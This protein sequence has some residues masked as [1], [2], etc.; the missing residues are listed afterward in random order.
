M[1]ILAARLDDLNINIAVLA[2]TCVGRFAVVYDGFSSCKDI[3]DLFLIKVI[4]QLLGR[5][6]E[7]SKGVVGVLRDAADCVAA[8]VPCGDL[9]NDFMKAARHKNPDVRR[10]VVMWFMRAMIKQ[11]AKEGGVSG[12]GLRGFLKSDIRPTVDLLVSLLED[13][14]EGVRESCAEV[15]GAM[16]FV[17]G[18]NIV[19]AIEKSV[20]KAKFAKIREYSSIIAGKPSVVAACAPKI[21]APVKVKQVAAS[22]PS[23][24]SKP[25]SK[26]STP[27][28]SNDSIAS[29]VQSYSL[30]YE[31]SYDSSKEHVAEKLENSFADLANSNWKLRLECTANLFARIENGAPN[32]LKSEAVIH[33]L[34]STPGYGWKESNF[35]VVATQIQ[36]FSNLCKRSDFNRSCM[37]L[38]V[39]AL[40]GKV[41]DSKLRAHVIEFLGSC[42]TK[43]GPGGTIFETYDAINAIKSPKSI[44]D[45]LKWINDTIASFGVKSIDIKGLTAFV[46][47]YCGHVNGSVRAMAI[48]LIASLMSSSTLVTT[49]VKDLSPSVLTLVEAE[50]VLNPVNPLDDFEE[51][52]VK[53]IVDHGSDVQAVDLNLKISSALIAQMK[54]ANWKERKLA[55]D[56]IL[57]IIAETPRILPQLPSEFMSAL[58]IRFNDGNKNLAA[59]ALE[60][61][62]GLATS[63]GKAF[64][65]QVRLFGIL[66]YT[67]LSDQK[68]PIRTHVIEQLDI[69]ANA[70]G[71]SCMSPS[72]A[73]CLLQENP[74]TRKEL[75]HWIAERVSR[76][77]LPESFD[78]M[79]IITSSLVYFY[80]I[81]G[82][83]TRS[84]C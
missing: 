73:A 38:I 23:G 50:V 7:K 48:S 9:V 81:L 55:M 69:I 60:I 77:R 46:K 54:D 36:I 42:S 24:K 78:A 74:N 13:G 82:L 30:S 68:Q 19:S 41:G 11:N 4:S 61:F 5:F 47:T 57:G 1:N 20:D 17:F 58:K 27:A 79:P 37:H 67:F 63:V 33:F 15:L 66:I 3:V 26:A 39:P 72:S 76:F 62:A 70:V 14:V 18:G 65:K 64:D 49:L 35:Q 22:K 45:A 28:Q 34:V 6:K 12:K 44:V 31:F 71:F 25:L 10:E 32:L 56:E 80:F 51:R 2:V 43:F 21:A 83:H 59:T 40:I 16:V 53:A 75:L 52:E 84:E 29:S 8:T